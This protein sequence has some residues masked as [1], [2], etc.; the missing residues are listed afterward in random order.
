MS[1]QHKFRVWRADEHEHD[2]GAK[3]HMEYEPRTAVL[4]YADHF[5]SHCDG[6]EASWPIDF[7][8]RDLG[9]KYPFDANGTLY[10]FSV[11]RES[12]PHFT[13]S[14]KDAEQL[15][16]EPGI[17]DRLIDGEYV[18]ACCHPPAF[19]GEC[20]KC[21]CSTGKRFFTVDDGG[22]T[23]TFVA[24]DLEH[25]KQMLRDVGAELTKEDGDSAGI[26]DPAFADLEWIE[27]TQDEASRIKCHP[28]DGG[29]PS[30]PLP[31]YELGAWFCSEY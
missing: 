1:G 19:A 11:D 21:L 27:H 22:A 3:E 16:L 25:C 28:D 24:R 15:K 7:I 8:V 29:K 30:Q 14:Y 18:C 5:Y 6:W 12:I 31:T 9:E 26:D 20:T 23:Y 2:G 17:H 10:K 4:R 13:T